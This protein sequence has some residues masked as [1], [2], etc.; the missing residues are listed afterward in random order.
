MAA[1]YVVNNASDGSIYGFNATDKIGF[2][3]VTP[4][5]RPS[6][7]ASASSSATTIA[8]LNAVITALGNLGLITAGG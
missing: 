1:K 5:V 2:F 6:V 4:I 7:S 3:G 8:Q